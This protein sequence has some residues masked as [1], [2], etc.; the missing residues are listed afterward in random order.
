MTATKNQRV[1][2]YKVTCTDAYLMSEQGTRYSL[3]PWGHDTLYYKGY[4]DGGSDYIMPDRFAL[5][6]D[7][8]GMLHVYDKSGC[9]VPIVGTKAPT[10]IDLD[11]GEYVALKM[12]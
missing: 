4:D 7:R 6:K 10:L 12:A 8:T 11:T 5:G 2:I 1:T 3:A 9:P